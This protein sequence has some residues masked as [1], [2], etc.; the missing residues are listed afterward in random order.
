MEINEGV[1]FRSACSGLWYQ[2]HHAAGSIAEIRVDGEK[3]NISPLA[4]DVPEEQAIMELDKFENELDNLINCHS[5]EN[6][7]DTPDYI[8]ARYLRDCL[9]TWNRAVRRRENWYGRVPKACE[10]PI[11]PEENETDDQTY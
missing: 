3:L 2:N 6:G 4:A 1:W 8:L 10:V 5:M 7:S 9:E 11:T